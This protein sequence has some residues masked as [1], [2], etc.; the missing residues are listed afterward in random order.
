LEVA[1]S[2][3]ETAGRLLVRAW[4]A[5]QTTGDPQFVV[6]THQAAAVYALWQDDIN[7]AHR[8]AELGWLR[9]SDTEDW[10]LMARMA[11]TY[12]EVDAAVVADAHRRRDSA[13]LADARERSLPVLLRAEAVVRACGVSPKTGSRQQA[14]LSIR[15]A[16]AFRFRIEDNDDP[17]TWHQLAADWAAIGQP[18]ESARALRREA[19]AIIE[20]TDGQTTRGGARGP[21]VGAA[22]AALKLGARPL[23]RAVA[24]LARQASIPLPKAITAAL[25]D[26]IEKPADSRKPAGRRAGAGADASVGP[27][28][29]EFA[30]VS[31][32]PVQRDFG[33][34]AREL[35]VLALIAEGLTNVEIGRRLAIS[36]KTVGA[37]V[38]SI[39]AK[40]GVSG[41]VEAAATAIRMGLAGRV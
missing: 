35:D 14:D 23:L 18:Y 7:D 31:G 9:V 22:E 10:I 11:E 4:T 32:E 29:A 5:I 2:A 25:D 40:L 27:V 19:E 1:V 39:L 24:E 34:S 26:S 6:P 37:H 30:A 13:S 3:G 16:R 21:L 12:L 17:A 15:T 33:L 41:R 28:A 20:R 38:G 8:S 36:P